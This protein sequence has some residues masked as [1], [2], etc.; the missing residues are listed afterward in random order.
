MWGVW[1]PS[2]VF[3]THVFLLTLFRGLCYRQTGLHTPLLS[4]LYRDGF[5]YWIFISASSA[6]NLVVLLVFP[7]EDVF[8]FKY[9]S[10]ATTLAASSHLIFNLREVG[11]ERGAGARVSDLLFINPS[12]T[13]H[14]DGG[15]NSCRQ[16]GGENEV[17]CQFLDQAQTQRTESPV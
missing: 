2:I 14:L 12:Q 9:V 15:Q 11:R 13:G 16:A 17:R 4:T 7:P 5:L 3:E 1:F 10:T 8:L 6:S